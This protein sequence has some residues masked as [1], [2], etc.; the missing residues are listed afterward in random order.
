MSLSVKNMLGGGKPEGLYAWKKL[1][2][3]GGDFIDYVVS[4]KETAYPDGGE[5]GGYWYEKVGEGIEEFLTCGYY[6]KVAIDEYIPASDSDSITVS[7][8]LG[9]KPEG[10]ICLLNDTVEDGTCVSV[11][12]SFG[13]NNSSLYQ[14]FSF[15]YGSKLQG[16]YNYA[17]TRNS[18]SITLQANNTGMFKAGKKYKVVT[19]A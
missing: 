18:S 9:V 3:Q 2:A 19:V 11:M 16:S 7:H 10:V 12:A 15:Y 8:S 5:K 1:S 14:P 17:Q 6:S 4:D 13:Y